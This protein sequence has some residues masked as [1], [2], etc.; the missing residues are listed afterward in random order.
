MTSS[1][2]WRASSSRTARGA[3][4]LGDSR[5]GEHRPA[6]G[7]SGGAREGDDAVASHQ[8]SGRGEPVNRKQSGHRGERRAHDDRAAVAA[9]GPDNGQRHGR[10]GGKAGADRDREEVHSGRDIHL[11]APEEV[12]EAGRDHRTGAKEAGQRKHLISNRATH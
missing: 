7:Q 3:A 9:P 10:R 6:D 8:D 11:A 4:Q 5:K 2:A 12:D 1:T